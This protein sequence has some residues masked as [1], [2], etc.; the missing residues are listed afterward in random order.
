ME[1]TT[2]V[3]P[4]DAL[5]ELVKAHRSRRGWSQTDLARRIGTLERMAVARIESGDRGVSLDEAVALAVALDVPLVRLIA[6]AEGSDR[7]ELG[8]GVECSASEAR[9][10]MRGD[11]MLPGQDRRAFLDA[12]MDW[13][14]DAEGDEDAWAT[15]A[16]QF[17]LAREGPAVAG[18]PEDGPRP[19]VAEGDDDGTRSE[20]R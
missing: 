3:T 16:M 18:P 8:T 4:T 13:R 17:E 5:R 11:R 12:L 15:A 19:S 2:R 7:V 10:W 14:L 9:A 1:G 6:P 20:A